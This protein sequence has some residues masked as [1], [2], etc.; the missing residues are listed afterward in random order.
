MPH[1][2]ETIAYQHALNEW[3]RFHAKTRALK[4]GECLLA[5][6]TTPVEPLAAALRVLPV[7]ERTPVAGFHRG[8]AGGNSKRSPTPRTPASASR[9]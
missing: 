6:E 7:G 2:P 8:P 5:L 9:W 1:Q 3:E 4:L